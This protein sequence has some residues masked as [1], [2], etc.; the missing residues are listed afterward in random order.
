MKEQAQIVHKLLQDS[1]I[2]A[3]SSGD[4]HEAMEK[5]GKVLQKIQLLLRS[6]DRNNVSGNERNE[7]L[8]LKERVLQEQKMLN[9]LCSELKEHTEVGSAFTSKNSDAESQVI[10]RDVWVPAPSD[11]R[12]GKNRPSLGGGPGSNQLA[13]REN[14]IHVNGQ[15]YPHHSLV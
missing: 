15:P 6:S 2:C 9:E 10:D 13:R 1:R 7:I 3:I 12:F 11:N 8:K 4:Y 14:S 5:H